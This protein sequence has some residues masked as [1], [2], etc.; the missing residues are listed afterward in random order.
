MKKISLL[1][2]SLMLISLISLNAEAAPLKVTSGQMIFGGSAYGSPDYQTYARF[3]MNFKRRNPL[4]NYQLDALQV[5]SVYLN[6]PIQPNGDF[7]YNVVMPYGPQ[8]LS[9]N[10][11]NFYPVFYEDCK[12]TIKTSAV[13]PTATPDSPQFVTVN[14]TFTISGLSAFA[15]ANSSVFKFTGGGTVNFIFQKTRPE[16]YHFREANYVFTDNSLLEKEIF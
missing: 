1:I 11:V 8:S 12:W 15:G 13:T 3:S 14:S 2:C 10:G 6:H 16:E 7:T 4:R 5:Y 9:V